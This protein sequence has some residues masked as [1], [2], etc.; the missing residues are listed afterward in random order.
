MRD[1][2]LGGN[3]SALDSHDS[4][5]GV[6][7]LPEGPFTERRGPAYSP[8]V[9]QTGEAA[10]E[11]TGVTHWWRNK[12]SELVRALNDRAIGHRRVLLDHHNTAANG[13]SQLTA[14]S[15][16]YPILVDHLHIGADAHIFVENCSLHH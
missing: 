12:I 15:L 7:Y 13:E 10:F 11:T 8:V 5:P 1:R 9:L 14:V 2:L 4:R 6:A 3:F 16:L